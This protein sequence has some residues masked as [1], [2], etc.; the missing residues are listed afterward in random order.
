M[1]ITLIGQARKQYS[2]PH[3]C[4]NMSWRSGFTANGTVD[5]LSLNGN[6]EIEFI[7]NENDVYA[8]S[9]AIVKS[10]PEFALRIAGEM[11]TEA[12]INLSKIKQTSPKLDLSKIEK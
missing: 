4:N 9:K 3:D 6:Y 11:Q 7:F 10:N 12:I 1:K 5:N 2:H 8:W